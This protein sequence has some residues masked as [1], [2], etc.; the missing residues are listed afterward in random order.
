MTVDAC[1]A[2]ESPWLM[3]YLLEWPVF[4]SP[5]QRPASLPSEPPHAS[6]RVC[7]FFAR[8]Y[9]AAT[10]PTAL[11]PTPISSPSLLLSVGTPDWAVLIWT[12]WAL[13]APR[14]SCYLA[15]FSFVQELE[16]V[17]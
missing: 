1:A 3:F 8:E 7:Y 13:A 9:L 15:N 11:C 17:P 5:L 2:D 16:I 6:H 10:H 4:A 14:A 12:W